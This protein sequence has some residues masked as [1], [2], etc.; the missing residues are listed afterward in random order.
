[1][2]TWKVILATLVIFA[3]GVVTGGLLV[4][5]AVKHDVTLPLAAAPTPPVVNSS[6]NHISQPAANPWQVQNR[7]LL[8][9]MEREIGLTAGQR[10][11][12]EQIITN[13][14]ERTKFIWKPITPQMSREMARV[15]HEMRDQLT[16]DQATK[17]DG[18]FKARPN[19]PKRRTGTN[20]TPD[21][22][23]SSLTNFPA[24]NAIPT[25]QPAPPPQQ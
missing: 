6:T 16:P 14:Q 22:F 1:V 18:F 11:Q 13:S 17:F 25:N 3:T 8:R 20:A 4:N 10:E 7:N 5:F 24:T 2:S 9:R 23:S 15:R 21:E 12:M 19:Q